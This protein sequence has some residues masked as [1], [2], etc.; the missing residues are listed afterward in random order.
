MAQQEE[1]VLWIDQR[2]KNAIEKHLRDETLQEHLENV[3][4]ELCN[5]LPEREYARISRAIQSEAAA[6]RAEEEAART[7]AAYHV[8]ERGQEWYFKTSPGEELLAVGKK[9]RGYITKDNG[10]APGKF[11]GMFFG[12]QPIT[13]K[14]FD[15]LTALRMENTGK[16]RGVFDVN[17]DKREFSAVHIMDG[18]Q[19][20]AMRDVSVAVYTDADGNLIRL[21]C[22]DFACAAEFR[23]WK[24]WSDSDLR[25]EENADHKQSDNSISLEVL[26]EEATAVVSI[27]DEYME[28]ISADE[29]AVLV[30]L[31]R[32][33]L[34]SHLT[35]TQ[36]RRLWKYCVEGKPVRLIAKEECAYR[37]AVWKSIQAAKE[38]MFK[39]LVETGC[40]K[41]R[42]RRDR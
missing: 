39:F 34:S 14:E 32:Q 25:K 33:G 12:G 41:P 4:D 38:K 11:I 22:D 20:W 36:R 37:N 24:D 8:T 13:A 5:Q 40:A 27:E 9:L 1:I 10:V 15:A 16:V 18:W 7:Y 2:W 3:L 42:F 17:F 31:L 35:E 30:R 26:S 6:Q 21:T 28:Q 19:T 23:R 29:A